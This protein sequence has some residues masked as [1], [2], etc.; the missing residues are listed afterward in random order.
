LKLFKPV[1]YIT[2]FTCLILIDCALSG[3]IG[4]WRERFWTSV[5]NRE[6][7]KFILYLSEFT[8]IASLGC[9]VSGYAQYYLNISALGLRT[10][11][12]HKAFKHFDSNSVEGGNQRVQEDCFQYPLLSLSI[13]GGLLRSVLIIS[14]LTYIL[15]KQVSWYFILIPF[16]YASLGTLLAG[17]IAFPLIELNYLNQVVEAAFRQALSKLNYIRVH[18]NNYKLFKNTKYLAFFQS[19]YNQIT[20]IVPYV[21]LSGL[22]FSAK[23]TFGVFMQVASAMA[24]I[25][26]N[27][28]FLI[29]SF[30]DINRLLSCRKRLKEIGVI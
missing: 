16:I 26:N 8:V 18:D 15:I 17:K 10:I 23:I 22:Y 21:I 3:Y 9:L 27:L 29:N 19:F 20:V 14:I 4:F 6:L 5:Q 30:N 12:T 7:M 25:I 13:F 28:S 2:I 1:K 24:E 11:L